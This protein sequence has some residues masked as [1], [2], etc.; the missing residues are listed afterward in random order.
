VK[1]KP[2]SVARLK[3]RLVLLAMAAGA[4][5]LWRGGLGL[6]ATQRTLVIELPASM[7]RVD[8][9]DVQLW[10]EGRLLFREQRSGVEGGVVRIEVD[11]R[12]G[13]TELVA[14]VEQGGRASSFVKRFDPLD[15][16]TVLLPLS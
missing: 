13:L 6:F 3:P 12:P 9:I 1:E 7:R 14:S 2:D 10:K 4:A 5:Y 16:D 15:N 8:A 11:L